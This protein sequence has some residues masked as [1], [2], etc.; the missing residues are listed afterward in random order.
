MVW[1]DGTI[2]QSAGDLPRVFRSRQCLTSDCWA[3][4]SGALGPDQLP[5]SCSRNGRV[6]SV[7]SFG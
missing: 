4:V 7:L 1:A 6:H 3:E 5:S 2:R